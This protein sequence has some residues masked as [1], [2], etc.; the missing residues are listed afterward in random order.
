M[1][2]RREPINDNYGNPTSTGEIYLPDELLPDYINTMGFAILTV[3]NDTV[4]GVTVNQTAYD[5]YIDAHPPAP[6]KTASEKRREAYT[7]GEVDGTDWRITFEGESKTCDEM[8]L[9]GM[10]Y[11]FRGEDATE[12]RTLVAAKVLEIRTAYP[13]EEAI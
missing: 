8:T 13:D 4:T 7:T 10:Q 9:L 12:I 6:P 1:Y 2:L 11:A 5:A 3:E